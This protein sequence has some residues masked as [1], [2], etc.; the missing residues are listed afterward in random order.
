MAQRRISVPGV[1]SRGGATIQQILTNAAAVG[2][3]PTISQGIF[4]QPLQ[5]PRDVDNSY[6]IDVR[7][8]TAPA[9]LAT[10]Q[11]SAFVLGW[12]TTLLDP[13]TNLITF[14][15]AGN[16]TVTVPNPWNT[17]DGLHTLLDDGSGH[18]FP[19]HS[20]PQD[21]L[22]GISV[23]RIGAFPADTLAIVLKMALSIDLSYNALCCHCSCP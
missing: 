11:P 8:W 12:S 15:P 7:I 9:G 14:G 17:S 13:Q 22:L 16:L 4:C 23:F 20:F 5:L 2:C 3:S 19:A 1:Q 10:P 6:P 18:T 21:A